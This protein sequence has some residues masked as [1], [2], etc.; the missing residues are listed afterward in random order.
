MK[1]GICCL[2]AIL[3]SG[4]LSGCQFKDIDKRSFV[5]AIG[6]DRPDD[7]KKRDQF[8]VTLKMGIP[9]GDPTKRSQES[10]VI[11][12]VAESVPEAIRLA[13]SKMDKE[14]DFSHCKA[15]IYGE[16]LVRN[17]ITPIVDWSSRRR[18][19]QLI[20]YCA[21]GMPNAKEVVQMQTKS[22]RL[23][24]NALILGLGKEGTES[25]YIKTV[26]SYDLKRRVT[27][28]GLDP[29]MPI[30]EAKHPDMLVIDKL[31]LFNKKKM[32]TVLSPEETRIYNL[33]T[34]HNLRSSFRVDAEGTS[35]DYN[36]E[37]S[38]S[39]YRIQGGKD[40]KAVIQYTL[41]G[42]AVLEE[43]TVGTSVTGPVMRGYSKAAGE[44]WK[45][46]GEQLLKKIQATGLDP[47]GWGLRYYSRNWN[48]AT[49]QEDWKRL[50]P[51]LEFQVKADMEIKYTG[52]IR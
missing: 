13:K 15:L 44:K 48:N 22:E 2:L 45:K 36:L 7:P 26:Y 4:T 47:I 43:N 52:M 1:K 21:V 39:R 6:I 14:V 31:A 30:V 17:N 41:S 5:L 12:E 27:E 20:M 42:R 23:P 18:D 19:I 37:A 40:G 16:S 32:V 50:Y 34:S 3:L 8:E 46:D 24:G 10:V 29:I 38:K 9:E 28:R 51:N 11:T 25:P 35:F 49:E 33:L